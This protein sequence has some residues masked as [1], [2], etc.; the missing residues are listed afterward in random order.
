MSDEADYILDIEGLKESEPSSG[1]P[2]G[3]RRWL[4]IQFHCCRVYQ[5]IYR[6]AA[7]NAYV[8]RCPKCL[9]EISIPI[10]P[11]GTPSRFFEAH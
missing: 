5:R 1:S 7:G 8:G 4:G 2:A 9:R 3:S 11:G 6:N 10:G